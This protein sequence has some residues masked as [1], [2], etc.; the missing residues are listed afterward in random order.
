VILLHRFYLSLELQRETT[1]E[2]A[3]SS[4]EAGPCRQWRR[5]KMLRDSRQQICEIERH[6]YLLSQRAGHDIGWE[7]A[8]RDWIEHH[9]AAWRE[10]WEEQPD[11]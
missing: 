8:A 7:A 1:I 5:E 3:L 11:E 10:W 6:K 2:E 9:A 4:W